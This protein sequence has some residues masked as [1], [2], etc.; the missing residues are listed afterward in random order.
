VQ[1]VSDPQQLTVGAQIAVIGPWLECGIVVRIDE[2]KV[3]IL[4]DENGTQRERY[5]TD[6]GII[7]YH[8]KAMNEAYRTYLVNDQER[9]RLEEDY[10][11]M[12]D[13]GANA[14]VAAI[15]REL[16]NQRHRDALTKN[17]T[18]PLSGAAGLIFGF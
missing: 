4:L 7:P 15:E 16:R 2:K 17:G 14:T 1:Q 13:A 18:V 9:E 8:W 3:T 5:L 11:E 6:M 10:T 12:I